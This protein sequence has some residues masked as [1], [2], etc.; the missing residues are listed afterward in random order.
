MSWSA[1]IAGLPMPHQ[2]GTGA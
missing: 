2:A 1:E